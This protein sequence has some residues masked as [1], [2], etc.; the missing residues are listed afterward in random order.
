[1][2][3]L[4]CDSLTINEI[5]LNCRL[6][7]FYNI[8]NQYGDSCFKFLSLGFVL[9]FVVMAVMQALGA[10]RL[11]ENR[12]KNLQEQ[13][14]AIVRS[15]IPL[16]LKLKLRRDSNPDSERATKGHRVPYPMKDIESLTRNPRVQGSVPVEFSE[17]QLTQPCQS[18]K[19]LR[20][21]LHVRLFIS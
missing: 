9:E 20:M 6:K 14:P 18:T 4:Y 17:S 3:F 19:L 13:S 11:E 21:Q 7:L 1:M 2:C 8:T 5:K 15:S 10:I 16:P 12:Y